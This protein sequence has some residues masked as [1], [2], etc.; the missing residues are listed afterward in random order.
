MRLPA[1]QW[2]RPAL[3]FWQRRRAGCSQ[4][5][6]SGSG[7]VWRMWRASRVLRRWVIAFVV[8]CKG[9][10]GQREQPLGQ[11][12]AW[13]TVTDRGE[14]KL[15]RTP[16][17]IAGSCQNAPPQPHSS[18]LD[19]TPTRPIPAHP[20]A[21]AQRGCSAYQQWL[22]CGQDHTHKRERP[23]QPWRPGCLS[24]QQPLW[25]TA[26]WRSALRQPLNRGRSHRRPLSNLLWRQPPPRHRPAQGRAAATAGERRHLPSVR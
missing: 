11:Q 15:H 17:N 26:L 14:A 13:G 21:G 5:G 19:F 9:M 4:R 7:S 24:P 25:R 22:Q 3:W 6:G 10:R 16:A 2:V 1:L 8:R 23:Q 18:A 12:M 20:P